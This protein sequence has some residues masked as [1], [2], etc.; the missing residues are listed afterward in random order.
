MGRVFG[1]SY[2]YLTAIYSVSTQQ[3]QRFTKFQIFLM[4]AREHPEV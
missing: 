2:L 3:N 4:Y 1:C